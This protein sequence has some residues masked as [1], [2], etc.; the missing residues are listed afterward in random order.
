MGIDI[1]DELSRFDTFLSEDGNINIV[2]SGIFGIGKTYFLRKYFENN[3]KYIP[4]YLTPINYI[5]SSNEDI[6]EYI[7]VDILFELIRVG[8]NFK[9][10]E[11]SFSLATQMYILESSNKLLANLLKMTEKIKFGT[12]FLEKII[13]FKREIE[14]YKKDISIDEE[15]DAIGFLRS[16]TEQSGT[17]FEDN[18][19][20]QL[21]RNLINSLKNSEK[22]IVLI[23]DDL[24]RIDPEHIF[25]ILNVLSAHDNFYETNEHKFG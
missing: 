15:E 18:A 20:T 10:E 4:I 8:A 25:R 13:N 17:I 21:I 24:D 3:D 11:C 14:D 1:K 9:K 6:F 16:Y 12:D 5:V 19:I 7:K 23:I 2:F 22:E